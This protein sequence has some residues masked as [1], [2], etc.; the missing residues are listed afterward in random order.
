MRA[1][2]AIAAGAALL[3]PAGAALVVHPTGVASRGRAQLSPPLR[4]A[5]PAHQS[6]ASSSRSSL[7]SMSLT[8]ETI[9]RIIEIV[10]IDAE[11]VADT[12]KQRPYACLLYTSPS[13]RDS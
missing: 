5:I 1:A 11:I 8:D 12:A 3:D 6:S 7:P 2:S 13:P 4:P 10:K 9:D